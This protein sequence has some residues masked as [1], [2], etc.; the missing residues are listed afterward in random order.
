[1]QKTLPSMQTEWQREQNV[2][3]PSE[4]S[5]ESTN[6]LGAIILNVMSIRKE[7]EGRQNAEVNER[8]NREEWIQAM[9]HEREMRV[10]GPVPTANSETVDHEISTPHGVLIRENTTYTVEDMMGAKPLKGTGP[11]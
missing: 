2:K 4:V 1:M 5:T 9:R 10:K 8:T 3:L 6:R 7:P 11:D